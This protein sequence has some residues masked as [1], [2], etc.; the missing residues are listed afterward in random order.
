M[1]E[2]KKKGTSYLT[3]AAPGASP[4]PKRLGVG[5][6]SAFVLLLVVT[7]FVNSPPE[8]GIPEGAEKVDVPAAVHV[9]GD[10]HSDDESVP[11][12]GPHSAVWQ[13]CGFYTQEVR[14]ENAV[15][16]LEHGAIWITY[17]ADLD[18]EDIDRLRRFVRPPDKILVSPVQGQDSP[19]VATAWA[20]QL[21]LD[22]AADPRLDQF[23][24]EFEGRGDAP[25]PGG[26]CDGG[27]G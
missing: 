10:I 13:N 22:D 17:R 5:A 19:I 16:S 4:W 27:I 21:E 24:N 1:T 18:S 12:G 23:V 3:S 14:S 15:H 6:L 26:R 7:V 2:R 11:P 20:Y 9:E 8:R 25:E